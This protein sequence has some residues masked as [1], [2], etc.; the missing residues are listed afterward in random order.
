MACVAAIFVVPFI[1]ACSN[2][3]KWENELIDRGFSNVEQDTSDSDTVVLNA[4]LKDSDC[5]FR[6]VYHPDSGYNLSVKDT[7]GHEVV[8]VTD[9][10][11]AKVRHEKQLDY[12]NQAHQQPSH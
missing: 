12:C 4:S 3:N 7:S 5:R 10:T 6:I 2:T 9:V 1:G 8:V 11:A